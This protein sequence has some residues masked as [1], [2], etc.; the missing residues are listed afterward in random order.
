MKYLMIFVMCFFAGL[1]F[2]KEAPKKEDNLICVSNAEL[3]KS[4]KDKSYEIG[5]AHV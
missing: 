2:A 3:D 4:M 1:S 5:R